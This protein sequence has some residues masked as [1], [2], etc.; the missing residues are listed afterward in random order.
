VKRFR[1]AL[2]LFGLVGFSKAPT[3]AAAVAGTTEDIS[4][5]LQRSIDKAS[6]RGQYRAVQDL[7]LELAEHYKRQ[8]AYAFAAR[9][10]ELLLASRPSRRER[11]SY[12]IELGKMQM[13]DK[14]YGGAI[15]AFQDAVHDDHNSW[16]ANLLLA[17]AYDHSE[18]N[19]KAIEVYQRC[20][21]LRP[22]S[23]EGFHGVARVY[24]QLGFLNKAVVN[25]QKAVILAKRPESYLQLS[26]TYVRQG[27][28]SRAKDILQQAKAVLPLADYDVRLGEIFQRQGDLKS[29]CSAWEEALHADAQ[30]DDVR[31]QLALAYDRLGRGSDSDRQFRR[32][33]TEFPASP[34]VHFSHAWV[35]FARGDFAGSRTEALAAR[36]LGPTATVGYYTNKLLAELKNKS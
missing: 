13:A 31:L 26:D 12:S 1:V 2:I 5:R 25:Y 9:Q 27:D 35:L 11:V 15:Q 34:V 30:R 19:T 20:I 24:Q 28:I 29:A 36:D 16:D 10:Y 33:L 3:G 4:A 7:R 23:W 17:R 6:E 22:D 21:E 14:N 8:S 18:L 32:L